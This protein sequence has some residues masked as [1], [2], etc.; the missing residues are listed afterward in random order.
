MIL[1]SAILMDRRWNI[2]KLEAPQV[3]NFIENEDLLTQ[4]QKIDEE[5][6]NDQILLAG[7]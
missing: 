4:V 3:W 6:P 5:R 7:T 2:H 1:M